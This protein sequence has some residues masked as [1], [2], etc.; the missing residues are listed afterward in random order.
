[1]YTLTVTLASGQA[2]NFTVGHLPRH[3][4]S[5]VMRQLPYATDYHGCAWRLAQS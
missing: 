1:M 2:H 4:Q 5:W 3:W